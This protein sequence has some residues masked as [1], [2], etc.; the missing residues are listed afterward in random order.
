MRF[1]LTMLL[2]LS[3]SLPLLFAGLLVYSPAA[4]FQIA[5]FSA[6]VSAA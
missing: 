4:W 6:T 2:R 1:K 5:S 3:H